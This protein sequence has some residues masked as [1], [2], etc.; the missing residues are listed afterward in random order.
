MRRIALLLLL[1][2]SAAAEEDVAKLARQL[3]SGKTY[4]RWEACAALRKLGPA[5][6]EA[7]PALIEAL[8]DEHVCADAAM[9]L[10]RIAPHDERVIEA[11]VAALDTAPLHHRREVVRALGEAPFH[12]EIPW[13]IEEMRTNAHGTADRARLWLAEILDTNEKRVADLASDNHRIRELA[14]GQIGN[15]GLAAAMLRDPHRFVRRAAARVLQGHEGTGPILALALADED[16]YTAYVIR[17]A[18]ERRWPGWA[19]VLRVAGKGGTLVL[20]L[21]P[22]PAARLLAEHTHAEGFDDIARAVAATLTEAPDDHLRYALKGEDPR[23]RRCAAL[24]LGYLSTDKQ[25]ARKTLE[26]LK[27][28]DAQVRGYAE[29]SLERLGGK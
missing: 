16:E 15:P 19:G 9:A 6:K 1:S 23:V 17:T 14:V 8:K 10:R 27:D 22:E 29:A 11:L 13:L 25:A 12:P 18:L 21:E 2:A 3:A 5:A 26:A 20:H 7:V 24:L 4:E 28:E